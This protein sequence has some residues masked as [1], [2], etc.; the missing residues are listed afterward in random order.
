MTAQLFEDLPEFPSALPGDELRLLAHLPEWDTVEAIEPEDE[1]AARR[2]E[3]RGLVR[4]HRWK[5]DPISIRP[6]LYGGKLSSA[7]LREVPK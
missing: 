2:L 4:L 6:T 5:D 1:A 7:Q 3:R